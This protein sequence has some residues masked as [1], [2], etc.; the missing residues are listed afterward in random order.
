MISSVRGGSLQVRHLRQSL[1][2]PFQS[3]G[4]KHPS[5]RSRFRFIRICSN[6][7]VLLTSLIAVST[8]REYFPKYALERCA[9]TVFSRKLPP[10]RP[11]F[12][13]SSSSSFTAS[14]THSIVRLA[15]RQAA[16][17]RSRESPRRTNEREIQCCRRL[18]LPS[19][20]FLG[21]ILK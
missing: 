5:T 6:Q 9:T 10:P 16:A 8:S 14:A 7:R 15:I 19:N 4:V 1:K 11:A 20:A 3:P 12:L 2:T 21:A 17:V 18:L 13:A